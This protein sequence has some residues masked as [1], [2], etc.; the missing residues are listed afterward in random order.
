[1]EKR[2]EKT[3]DCEISMLKSFRCTTPQLFWILFKLQTANHGSAFLYCPRCQPLN[4]WI[5]RYLKL[6]HSIGLGLDAWR[7]A[8]LVWGEDS[9]VTC[10]N[11]S[12]IKLSPHFEGLLRATFVTLGDIKASCMGEWWKFDWERKGVP[13]VSMQLPEE[14]HF[15]KAWNPSSCREQWRLR[16]CHWRCESFQN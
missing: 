16:S 1:M 14:S 10:N 2:I 8:G 7:L 5:S 15:Q 6:H 12:Q 3:K 9:W 4:N 11:S 13:G